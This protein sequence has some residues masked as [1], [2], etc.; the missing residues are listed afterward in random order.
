VIARL[1]FFRDRV[2]ADVRAP[3]RV[4]GFFTLPAGLNVFGVRF[5]LAGHPVVTAVLAGVAAAVWLVLTYGVP[6]SLLLIRTRESVVA[7]INGSWLLRIVATRS[8]AVV[9]ATAGFVEGFTFAMGAFGTWW[10]PLLVVRRLGA[11]RCRVPHLARPPSPS[12][13]A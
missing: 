5:A 3:D 10:I 9:R 1:A 12:S 2:A 11:G 7:A 6:A 13:R 4:F 8:L